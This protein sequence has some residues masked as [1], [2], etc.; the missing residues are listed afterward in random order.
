MWNVED[1]PQ[2]WKLGLL[3]LL[4]NWR[5]QELEGHHAP[6]DFQQGTLQDHPE[7]G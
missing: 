7:E 5:L 2:D 6:D 4:V 3:G 1:I